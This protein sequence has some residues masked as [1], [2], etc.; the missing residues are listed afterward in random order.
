MSKDFEN[1]YKQT[2]RLPIPPTPVNFS[3]QY[4]YASKQ[5]AGNMYSRIFQRAMG[6]DDT[7]SKGE[8]MQALWEDQKHRDAFDSY[9]STKKI[10][11]KKSKDTIDSALAIQTRSMV[12]GMM[13]G[14]VKSV[15]QSVIS[16]NAP[17]T[18]HQANLRDSVSSTKTGVTETTDSTSSYIYQSE[19]DP[20]SE[21]DSK[22]PRKKLRK[23]P[24]RWDGSGSFDLAVNESWVHDGYDMSS[25]LLGYT[26]LYLEV[27]AECPDRP[28]KVAMNRIFLLES[29]TTLSA[30]L[31][32]AGSFLFA[33]V[34]LPHLA[35]ED[36]MDICNISSAF[37]EKDSIM[38]QDYIFSEWAK[39]R[40]P[41]DLLRRLVTNYA[42]VEALWTRPD[43]QNEDTYMHD[44][45]MPILNCLQHPGVTRYLTSTFGPSLIRSQA[46]DPS[47][48]GIK[49]DLHLVTKGAYVFVCEGKKPVVNSKFD[50]EKIAL[51]MK[52]SIDDA[53]T[54]GKRLERVFGCQVNGDQGELLSM[55][56]KAES[57][58]LMRSI[59][60]SVRPK[61]HTDMLQMFLTNLPILKWLSQELN[62][63]FETLDQD[64]HDL[65]TWIRPSFELPRR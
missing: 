59:G 44:Y 17:S 63:S 29:N 4:R 56:L 52:D 14:V 30:H 1:R 50:F 64:A 24:A 65:K 23:E 31:S 12:A 5:E 57:I 16:L 7:K 45:F 36:V 41:S 51:E 62:I 61:N 19:Q 25:A 3:K 18:P 2:L 49:S 53:I 54:N 43:N 27:G 33:P 37:R 55:E 15:K 32:P 26:E 20:D 8:R 28:A 13:G 35:A 11:F 34:L 42:Q 60:S 38:I 48:L 58:Y 10:K 47:S 46:F 9:W 6:S 40:P 21:D 39:N 22:R